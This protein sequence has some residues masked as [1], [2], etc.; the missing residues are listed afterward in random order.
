[1]TGLFQGIIDSANSLGLTIKRNKRWTLAMDRCP[2]T[3]VFGIGQD[4]LA[5]RES[6]WKNVTHRACT[7]SS[8]DKTARE[9]R[10]LQCNMA[11]K[12]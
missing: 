2:E 10:F 11:V 12:T 8:L 9:Y 3:K 7:S 6:V 5:K 4:A 1:M